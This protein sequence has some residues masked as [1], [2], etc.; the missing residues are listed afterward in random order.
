MLPNHPIV[1]VY[2]LKLEEDDSRIELV[3]GLESQQLATVLYL[4]DVRK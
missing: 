4:P 2:T 3:I 1:K